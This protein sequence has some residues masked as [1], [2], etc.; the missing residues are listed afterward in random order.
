MIS[1]EMEVTN[2]ITDRS[3]LDDMSSDENL[4]EAQTQVEVAEKQT[5]GEKP[6][7]EV[8]IDR[9]KDKAQIQIEIDIF[10]HLTKDKK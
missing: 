7:V 3:L 8:K 4:N 6:R 9:D 1:E 2:M 5:C 10:A